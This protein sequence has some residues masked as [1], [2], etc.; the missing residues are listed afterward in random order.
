MKRFYFLVTLVLMILAAGRVVAQ[1]FSNKGK[2]FWV[3]YGYHE[4]MLDGGNK[5]E[6]V[7]YFA[8]EAV[9]T[10]KVSIPG[11]GYSVTYSNI[12]ANTVFTSNPIPKAGAQDARLLIESVSPE[13][14]GIHIEADHPIVAYAHI[15]NQSVSGATILFPTNIL[16][17][18]Y[19]SVNYKNISNT[20]NANCWFYVVACDTGTT[21]I[22]I[23]PSAAT[24]NHPAGVPFTVNLTQGQVYNIMGQLTNNVGPTFTGVDLTGSIIK[25]IS[26]VN[27]ICKRIA[28]FSGSGR[29]SITCDGASSSSDNYMVQA[30]PKSA[31]GKYYLTSPTGGQMS[32]NFFRICVTDPTTVVTVNGA[33]I[34][35]PL[36]NN[37]YYELP[38][39][40]SPQSIQSDKPI[41]VAQYITSQA[42][43]GNGPD[44]G[45]PE[46][47]YLSPVEQN[48]NKVL[49]NATP[50]YLILQ[51]YFNVIIPNTG[52]AI[53]S[54]KLDGISI[55]PSL[56]TIHPQA[57]G[58]S[59]LT[60]SVSVGQHIISS[61]SG[62]NAIA[63]GFGKFESYGYNA[64]TNVKDLYQYVSIANQYGT[65][66]YPATCKNSPFRLSM[67]FP[68][69]PIQIRW[70]FGGLFPNVTLTN[71][72]YDSTWMINGKQ[73][74]LYKITSPFIIN[75]TG[76]Y[77]IKV[78]AQNPTPEGCSGEQEIDYDLQVYEPP[79]ADFNFT[80][81][82][83]ATDTIF[84]T[85]N[86]NSNGRTAIKWNWNFG[87]SG[88]DS[89][90]N[91]KH[92]YLTQ[93]T[94]NVRH[95]II[96]DVG[97]ISD[98]ASKIITITDPPVAKFTVSAPNCI[99]KAITFSDNSIP[100]PGG[101]LV[102]WY[103][104]FGDGTPQVIATSNG[105][106][107]HVY[108]STGSYNVT[109]KVET[110]S[111]CQSMPFVFPVTIYPNPVANFSFP[112]I[113]LPA[114]ASQFTDLSTISD[115]SQSL[116]SY[117]W[118]FGDG[119]NSVVKN[120]LHNYSGTGPYNAT[121]TV[122]SNNG[123]TDDTTR[124]VN[125]IF[126]EPVAAF[127]APAE[128]CFGTPANFNDQSTASGS[129]ISQWNWDFGDGTTSNAQNPVKNYSS[130]GTYTVK[131][132]VISAI[133]CS[134]VNNIAIKNIIINPLPTANFNF[135]TPSCEN[136]EIT[137]SDASVANAG[138]LNQW[139]WTYG[140]GSNAVL[141]SGNPFTHYYAASGSYTVSLQVKSDKGCA[142]ISTIKQLIIN[143]KPVAGFISPQVC[144]NDPAAPFT[145]TS[146]VVSG[147]I[148]GWNWDFGDGSS[149]ILQNPN[150]TY[151]AVGSYTGTLIVTSNQGCKDT[152]AQ[153][154]TVNGSLPQAA[155]TVQNANSLCSNQNVKLT[156]ASSVNFGNLI[157]LEIYWDYANDPTIKTIDSTP[158]KGRVYSHSYP[159]FN[160]PAS[161]TFTIQYVAYS[162]ITCISTITQTI[163]LL[164][165]PQLQ[166][167]PVNE[168]CT[169]DPAFQI[170]QA[171][172][173]NGLPGSGS[174]S[175][176]GVS[177]SGIFNPTT[178]EAG[179]QTI[180]YTYMGTNGCVNFMEQ[181]IPVNPTPVANAGPDKVVL[182][183]GFVTLTPVLINGIP[184]TYLWSPSTGLNN[185]NIAA[186]VASP[187]ED[188]TYTLTVTSDKGCTTNDQVYVE[189]LKK[190]NIPNI[191][192]PNG[193][194]VHDQW[195]I[196][197]LSSYP[198][199]TVDIYNRYGQLIF[200]SV[201][202]NTPWDGTVNGKQVPVGTYYYIVDPKNGR[203]KMSGYVDVIR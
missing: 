179:L 93:G 74:Y 167:D 95:S 72:V 176:P 53:S 150:H 104:N 46:V 73:L 64:G 154:F 114:G 133:G 196:Q 44:L 41:L 99:G 67:T 69:Q 138:N 49:W 65:V 146:H 116:F 22:E 145:D 5:Q 159:E 135:S 50:N 142:S 47:I 100:N 170:T 27:G 194:G 108:T 200:H 151:S 2:D 87:D 12:P 79:H 84:F 188:I 76:T 37:F 137:I 102:K 56:F 160:S 14:K 8:T 29:I 18:E 60:Q 184:V 202:Y 26:S 172:L 90:K 166:F 94:Y 203:S 36:Q 25:S 173:L 7:L 10:V 34:G 107:T 195:E 35:V 57:P 118:S 66:N 89:V 125:T 177:A 136:T 112:N 139:N 130:A 105:A 48:I 201:G 191:F 33:P 113:C 42:A 3:A 61:D 117:S 164:A 155:F 120:P 156:D 83:C 169:N 63:Y 126:A 157:R 106:Q 88:I 58:Y 182:E 121:L 141:S 115:G 189:V 190:P 1:D 31:W 81:T 128:V 197:Y 55:S 193:D 185:P 110:T 51:H 134:T 198:G 38:V 199:C 165:T 92:K 54:F 149:S 103:W 161:K 71:P 131:L 17:K 82:G 124:P 45:D 158:V 85:D 23:T 187:T 4:I 97:C 192:S 13:S 21:T 153:S 43:C 98:T 70:D 152:V 52:T 91:T 111:G 181:I 59:Y 174:F 9:T 119:G 39:T 15:Y 16:G 80:T 129:T 148:A 19:Y 62:F 109:L 32:F 140:D 40:A 183:G 147:A 127:N 162:G 20:P 101:T 143:P 75:N 6:M 122:T 175:G 132:S 163:T 178:A 30:F 78:F 180:R 168:V 11:L 77:P 96:T 28:V 144:L 86:S 186:A 68:Y 24:I 123:C 171:R